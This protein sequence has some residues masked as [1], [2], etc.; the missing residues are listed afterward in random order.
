MLLL[1]EARYFSKVMLLKSLHV[2][3]AAVDAMLTRCH[4]RMHEKVKPISDRE[5]HGHVGTGRRVKS[6]MHE[7][8]A[9][10]LP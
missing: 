8:F 4:H 1:V 7:V 5:I 9:C 3:A 2:C 10:P 6:I